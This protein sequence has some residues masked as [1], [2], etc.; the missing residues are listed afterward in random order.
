MM[1]YIF[2]LTG[3]YWDR[4]SVITG[5]CR[6]KRL[7]STTRTA[8]P[9]TSARPAAVKKAVGKL[10]KRF[11]GFKQQDAQEFLRFLL[12]GLHDDLNR[13]VTKPA[14]VELKDDPEQPELAASNVWWDNYCCRNNSRIKDLFC[15]QLRSE[16]ICQ[17]CQS[18]SIA[19]DPFWDLSVSIPKKHQH[20]GESFAT[21]ARARASLLQTALVNKTSRI[22]VLLA[23]YAFV[24]WVLCAMH[25]IMFDVLPTKTST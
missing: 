24:R 12:D 19:Y 23:W 16:V 5:M 6:Y 11:I 14:Y 21:T 4:S 9:F 18:C 7:L 17:T 13:V 8:E 3:T 25:L 10:A 2:L 22:D 1:M 20:R 15:G